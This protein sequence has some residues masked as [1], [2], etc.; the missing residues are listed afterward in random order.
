MEQL[1]LDTSVLIDIERGLTNLRDIGDP[2]DDVAI[3]AVTVAEFAV[4]IERA[5]TPERAA[6][7]T[8]ALRTW[9]THMRVLDYTRDTA[10]HHAR[11]LAAAAREGRVRGPYDIIIAAHAVETGRILVTSDRTATLETLPGIRTRLH[12]RTTP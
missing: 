3:A 11:L 12:P 7:R 9:M 6:A 1:I 4:G 10:R 8:H 5:A 2:D